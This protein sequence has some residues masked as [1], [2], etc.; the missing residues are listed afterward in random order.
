MRGLILGVTLV[1]GAGCALMPAPYDRSIAHDPSVAQRAVGDFAPDAPAVV[2]RAEQRVR[3]VGLGNQHV[4]PRMTLVDTYRAVRIQSARGLDYANVVVPFGR[5]DLASLSVVAYHPDGRRDTL[6]LRDA[7]EVERYRPMGKDTRG[8]ASTIVPVPGATI[9]TVVELSYTVQV[10]SWIM[11]D[12]LDPRED[13]P[14][15]SAELTVVRP[16]RVELAVRWSGVRVAPSTTLGDYRVERYTLER[17]L[18]EEAPAFSP[19]DV[20]PRLTMAWRATHVAGKSY[21]FLLGWEVSAGVYSDELD[22]AIALD[23]RVPALVA[24]TPRGRITEAYARVQGALA[25]RMPL[26]ANTVRSA[27]A[28]WDSGFGSDFERAQLLYAVLERAG[29]APRFVYIPDEER[30]PLVDRLPTFLTPYEGSMLVAVREG[31]DGRE[32]L[33][34]TS[35]AGCRAG[36]LAFHHQRRQALAF[37]PTGKQGPIKVGA[38]ETAD[39]LPLVESRFVVT[40]GDPHRRPQAR[41]ATLELTPRG[42]LVKEARWHYYGAYGAALRQ[43][44][45]SEPTAPLEG[46]AARRFVDGYAEGSMT[47]EVTDGSTVTLHLR[48]VLLARSGFIHAPPHV[49]VPLS[50]VMPFELSNELEADE[51]RVGTKGRALRFPWPLG[52]RVALR[53]QLAAGD[54]VVSTPSA[55]AITRGGASYHRVVRTVAG[56]VLVEESLEL[57]AEDVPA[58]AYAELLTFLREVEAA[59]A[60]PLV[61]ERPPGAPLAAGGPSPS[62]ATTP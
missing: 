35:C 1:T 39:Q 20:A 10:S 60:E 52:F 58:D 62:W 46:A 30:G 25:D 37:R 38:H 40:P 51:A 31:K 22:K 32:W 14:V 55:R 6:G 23:A 3:Y 43:H 41:E 54:R 2:L 4:I 61:L 57:G 53:F 16:E 8:Y 21:G 12:E 59:R 45:A 56:A 11:A 26:T 17:W 9:G 27:Q 36:E 5:R 49:V 44:A 15:L 29:L 48:D 19:I 47:V 50:V 42:L 7:L 13:L 18:P 28:V 33:L 34:D 24:T